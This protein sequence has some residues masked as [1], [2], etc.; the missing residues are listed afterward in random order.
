MFATAF[1]RVTSAAIA[2]RSA[3]RRA[4]ATS[5]TRNSVSQWRAPH[6]SCLCSVGS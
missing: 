5:H 6:A 3:R 4:S 2:D 1:N